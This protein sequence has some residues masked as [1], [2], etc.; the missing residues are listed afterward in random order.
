VIAL[1][2]AAKPDYDRC[3]NIF[4]EGLKRRGLPQDGKFDFF[5][6]ATD[7]PRQ[8]SS[9]LSPVKAE[10]RPAVATATTPKAPVKRRR[11]AS[12]VKYADS[13]SQ[14]SPVSFKSPKEEEDKSENGGVDQMDDFAKK[15]ANAAKAPTKVMRNRSLSVLGKVSKSSERNAESL[16]NPTPA[17]MALMAKKSDIEKEKKGRSNSRS[18]AKKSEN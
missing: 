18:L 5:G 11:R 16:A 2:F 6:D 13:S 1:E 14:T 3:R 17:M 8:E 10:R 4:K 12:T 15:S 7:L 9:S